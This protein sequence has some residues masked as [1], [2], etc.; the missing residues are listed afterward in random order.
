MGRF[1]TAGIRGSVKTNVTPEL[2]VSVGRALGNEVGNIVVGRDGRTTGEALLQ[3]AVAGALSSG[4]TVDRIGIV[5]TSAL[6]FESKGC[7]GI[8]I[9]ASHN[10]P[11][12]NGLKLFIDGQELTADQETTIEA[13]IEQPEPAVD[14]NEWGNTIGSNSVDRYLDT[15]EQY[16]TD[17][18]D[19]PMPGCSIAIDCGN[20][21]GGRVTPKL[22]TRLGCDVHVL[23]G[24]VDGHFPARASKP[25]EKTLG[26]LQNYVRAS[27]AIC[28]FAHDGDADRIVVLD[29]DGQIVHEDTVLAI[30]AHEYVR[31]SDVSDPIVLTTIN[32]SSRIDNHVDR[33]GGR[34]VRTRLGGLHDE[35]HHRIRTNADGIVV[36]AAEPWKHMHPALGRWIDGIVSAGLLASLI[37]EAGGVRPLTAP[38][39]EL[40]YRKTSIPCDT[41][42]HNDLFADLSQ[43]L[44]ESY[45]GAAIDTSI[46]IRMSWDEGW[47]LVRP[48]GTEP[49][50]RLYIEHPRA[51]ELESDL[52]QTIR[53]VRTEQ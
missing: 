16:V 7:A 3:S 19:S 33:V 12:D 9:T 25:Q 10:P 21:T 1:G 27:E 46:G 2:A 28:G 20:G 26:D 29:S 5:P 6:A 11:N 24:R 22:L 39:Q 41:S 32:A 51:D 37:A 23:N 13:A 30:L 38:I 36:F 14:W 40:P 53:A 18:T 48:S 8:M 50:I 45:P 34:I 44:P 49:K 42:V 15:V 52:L 35:I 4:A 43:L 31:Q 47:A 17:F